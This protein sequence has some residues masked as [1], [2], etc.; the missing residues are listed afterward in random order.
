MIIFALVTWFFL[1]RHKFGAHVY[2]TGDNVES[3]RLM[4]VN[5]GRIK[6]VTFMMVGV[7]AAF[8]GFLISHSSYFSGPRL[9]MVCC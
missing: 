2:L 7:A 8:S 9:G 1:N 4:G 6:I 5:T 3:A